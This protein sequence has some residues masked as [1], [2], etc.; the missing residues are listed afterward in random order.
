L[1]C[2]AELRGLGLAPAIGQIIMSRHHVFVIIDD[3]LIIQFYDHDIIFPPD[4]V[5]LPRNVRKCKEMKMS[6]PNPTNS[7]YRRKKKL[8]PIHKL[9]RLLVISRS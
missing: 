4:K 9:P 2:L 5:T 6:A 1:D 3:I 8:K 7:G